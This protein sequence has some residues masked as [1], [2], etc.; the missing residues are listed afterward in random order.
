MC[1]QTPWEKALEF[2][3]HVCPGLVLGFRAAE[4]GLRELGLELSPGHGAN[5]VCWAE[6]R[7][8]AVDAIQ[9]VTGCTLGKAN[10]VVADHGKQVFTFARRDTAAAV[11]VALKPMGFGLGELRA[12]QEEALRAGDERSRRAFA[13]KREEISDRLLELP[14]EELFTVRPVAVELPPQQRVRTMTACGA[15]GEGVFA[16]RALERGEKLLCR[17]CAG[18]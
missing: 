12:L 11:R 3:G 5:L 16:D 6:N 18:E 15:C 10:L 8:C 4:I 1:L 17:P 13:R 7:A 2:H 14:E 9:A